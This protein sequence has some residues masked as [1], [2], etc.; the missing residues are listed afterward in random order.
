MNDEAPKRPVKI[1]FHYKFWEPKNDLIGG[2]VY[3]GR[4]VEFEPPTSNQTWMQYFIK[5]D[6]GLFV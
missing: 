6:M 4:W 1:H 5:R 2:P 3:F